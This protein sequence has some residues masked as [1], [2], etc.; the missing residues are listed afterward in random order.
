MY[1][2]SDYQPKTHNYFESMSRLALLSINIFLDHY[3]TN[4]RI[5]DMFSEPVSIRHLDIC[6]MNLTRGRLSD[7]LFSIFNQGLPN[8]QTSLKFIVNGR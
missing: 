2:Y 4:S 6:V 3:G 5:V 8:P 7:R 1:V